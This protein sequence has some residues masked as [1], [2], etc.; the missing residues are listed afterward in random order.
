MIRIEKSFL[1][2]L[3]RQAKSSPRKRQHY[4]LH[5]D[6]SQVLQRFLNAVEPGSYIRPHRH[7]SAGKTEIF[8]PF[9]GKFLVL[10]FNDNGEIIDHQTLIP[11]ESPYAVEIPPE[12]Y[13]TVSSLESGSVAFE[14]KDGPFDP[15][16]AKDFA[17]WAPEE[18]TPEA[19][20][21]LKELIFRTTGTALPG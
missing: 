3:I 2:N 6:Y 8:I 1:E 14:I 4:N 15:A 13:H 16:A 17:S 18:N 20:F 11:F 5:K 21:Y 9:T 12:T 10:I 7:L 19:D